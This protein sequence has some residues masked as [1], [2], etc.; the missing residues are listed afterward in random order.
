MTFRRP[1]RSWNARDRRRDRTLGGPVSFFL[2]SLALGA[3]LAGCALLGGGPRPIGPPVP[4]RPGPVSG[5]SLK[6][7]AIVPLTGPQ[8]TYGL[9]LLSGLDYGM[10]GSLASLRGLDVGADLLETARASGQ[11]AA[12]CAPGLLAGSLLSGS[13]AVMAAAA[14]GARVPLLSPVSNEKRVAFLGEWVFST[15]PLRGQQGAELGRACRGLGARN[16]AVIVPEE[17]RDE[18]LSRSF[19]AALPDSI[20]SLVRVFRYRDPLKI[21]KIAQELR[22]AIPDAVL[23]DASRSDVLELV[24]QLAYYEVQVRLMGGEELRPSRMPVEMTDRFEGSVF[25]GD[26]W[27]YE[28]PPSPDPGEVWKAEAAREFKPGTQEYELAVS[29]EMRELAD[30][31]YAAGR[32]AAWIAS[33][34]PSDNADIRGL[35]GGLLAGAPGDSAGQVVA[36][37]GGRVRL[38]VVEKGKPRPL[39]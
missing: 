25:A 9:A 38:Y 19:L 32:L 35:L 26:T 21:G 15:V 36:P 10:A 8:R 34:K 4:V 29:L 3:L 5:D 39:K 2:L 22:A 1:C 11:A 7:M 31:G 14:Q 27:G 28:P 12:D 30:R 33:R 18:S 16:L 37:P 17:P 23:L 24:S 20:R 13:T 6:V